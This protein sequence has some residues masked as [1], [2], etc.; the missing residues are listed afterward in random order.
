MSVSTI[1]HV[2][3]DDT[4]HEIFRAGGTEDGQSDRERRPEDNE[5]DVGMKLCQPKK[6]RIRRGNQSRGRRRCD[7]RA[8]T[9]AGQGQ[10]EDTLK[11]KINGKLETT[12]KKTE[13]L[14]DILTTLK[15][16]QERLDS[17]PTPVLV[18]DEDFF[19]VNDDKAENT[20]REALWKQD[21][22]LKPH[23]CQEKKSTRMTTNLFVMHF[24]LSAGTP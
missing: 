6:L 19:K 2:T 9:V 16:I 5:E 22:G 12:E 21:L 13:L 23:R 11:E 20:K 24:E 10:K 4:T 8:Q 3:D 7:R 18:K 14:P 1:F 17:K 15:A